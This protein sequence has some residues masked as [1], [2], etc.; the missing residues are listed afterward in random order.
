[1]LVARDPVAE[2]GVGFQRLL[3]WSTKRMDRSRLY[4]YLPVLCA[5]AAVIDVILAATGPHHRWSFLGQAGYLAYLAVGIPYV[6]RRRRRSAAEF[7]P[8][9]YVTSTLRNRHAGV[10]LICG[11]T[12]GVVAVV[13]WPHHPVIAIPGVLAIGVVLF[14]YNKIALGLARRRYEQG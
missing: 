6:N 3:A 5:V 12:G 14:A 7:V 10:L 8:P 2:L 1:V 13:W 11:L 9:P 4:R